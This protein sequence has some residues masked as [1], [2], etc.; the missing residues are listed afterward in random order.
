M[1][2]ET[3]TLASVLGIRQLEPLST[4]ASFYTQDGVVYLAG[5]ENGLWFGGTTEVV[6]GKR[7]VTNFTTYYN[8]SSYADWIAF[9]GFNTGGWW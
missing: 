7:I 9:Y 2:F 1:G 8:A 3:K 5:W 4:H 6:A